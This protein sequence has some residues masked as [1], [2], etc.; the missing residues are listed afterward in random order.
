MVL[1][2]T[3]VSSSA[4]MRFLQNYPTWETNRRARI[5]RCVGHRSPCSTTGMF[6]R[7]A[8][9]SPPPLAHAASISAR[10]GLIRPLPRVDVVTWRITRG[11]AR[12][13]AV[14]DPALAVEAR[15]VTGGSGR[16]AGSAANVGGGGR[17]GAPA[18]A[19]PSTSSTRAI[20]PTDQRRREKD[21]RECA[22]QDYQPRLGHRAFFSLVSTG[23]TRFFRAGNGC[24]ACPR[25]RIVCSTKGQTVYKPLQR[26]T[27]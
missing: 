2:R 1:V 3:V 15:A 25:R 26:L 7:R 22:P 19:T 14:A 11:L 21:R 8:S 24:R 17:G 13:T 16:A 10:R 23:P 12:S 5:A 27:D 20:G 4:A 18:R 9:G 6:A